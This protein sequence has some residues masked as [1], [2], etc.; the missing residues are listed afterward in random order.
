[1]RAWVPVGRRGGGYDCTC[2]C[3]DDGAQAEDGA[4]VGKGLRDATA[5]Q[6]LL[7]G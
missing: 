5:W 6:G 4:Q 1:L 7:V 2:G 3:V